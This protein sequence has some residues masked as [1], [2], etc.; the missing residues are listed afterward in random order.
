M[1][2]RSYEPYRS[3][4]RVLM[5]FTPLLRHGLR[6]ALGWL[7]ERTQAPIMRRYINEGSR[8][9]FQRE[10]T[11][12]GASELDVLFEGTAWPEVPLAS[13]ADDGSG[14]TL[15]QK[16]RAARLRVLGYLAL[17]AV[18]T[19]WL[20]AASGHG[21]LARV[22]LASGAK[23]LEQGVFGAIGLWVSFTRGR[24]ALQEARELARRQREL[25]CNGSSPSTPERDRAV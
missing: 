18:A 11:E 1:E 7:D 4:A 25:R 16:S 6:F 5:A 12:R 8:R 9:Y 15:A 17:G 24:R 3:R 23:R 2:R 20:L 10:R 14:A 19:L 22:P 21:P 13:G